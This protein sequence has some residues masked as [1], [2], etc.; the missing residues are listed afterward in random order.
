MGHGSRVKWVN[1]PV[2]VTWVGCRRREL[3]SLFR[4][5][6]T[7]TKNSN[8]RTI[9]TTTKNPNYW[10]LMKAI[11]RDRTRAPI[12][13][14]AAPVA[15]RPVGCHMPANHS[16]CRYAIHLDRVPVEKNGRYSGTAQA[17]KES[18]AIST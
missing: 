13:H 1:T 7:T 12:L 15:Y 17:Q 8:T 14:C 3:C 11:Y 4:N 9:N 18:K 10:G 6:T 2:W 16:D 5:K